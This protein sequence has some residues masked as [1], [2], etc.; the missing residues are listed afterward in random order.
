MSDIDLN[1]EIMWELSC[2]REVCREVRSIHDE[3][4]KTGIHPG[5]RDRTAAGA[6]MAQFYNGI[7]N[8]L[9]RI[10][11]TNNKKMPTG[12]DWHIQII[13]LFKIGEKESIWPLFDETMF[14]QVSLFRSY[15][16]IVRQ[17]YGFQLS[18]GK[19]LTG[20]EQIDEIFNSF[21]TALQTH[22][23]I[24]KSSDPTV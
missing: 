16:H 15:R 11:R 7:E 20:L 17:S 8:I 13:R 1:S 4:L 9:K 10:V 21:G 5:V 14:K 6:F 12:D 23:F 24:H 22:G 2:M 18:W 19:L 3:F